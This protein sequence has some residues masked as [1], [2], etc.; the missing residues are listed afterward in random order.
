MAYALLSFYTHGLCPIFPGVTSTENDGSTNTFESCF[1]SQELKA[2]ISSDATVVIKSYE[3]ESSKT[4]LTEERVY[5]FEEDTISDQVPTFSIHE[6]SPLETSSQRV[7]DTHESATSNSVNDER[8]NLN[9]Q[10]E[11][12]INGEVE[13]SESAKRTVVARK[14]EKKGSAVG[15]IHGKFNFGQKSQDSSPRKVIL[16]VQIPQWNTF[17]SESDFLV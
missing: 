1:G 16:T 13:A 5:N 3:D 7:L 17:F 11:V 4:N 15:I 14:V 10:G 6:K 9:Q 12:L 2:E 8:S